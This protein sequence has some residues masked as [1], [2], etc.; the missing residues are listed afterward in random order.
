MWKQTFVNTHRGK[1]EVFVSGTGEPLC[2]THL[3]SEFNIRGN[4]F[5]DMFLDTFRV[6]LVNLKETGNS[7]KAIN[8]DELSMIETVK[9]LEAIRHAISIP[10]FLF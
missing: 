9:N 2:V 7:S 4:Y 6:Y 1:F 10:F 5:A 3:Y 8:K